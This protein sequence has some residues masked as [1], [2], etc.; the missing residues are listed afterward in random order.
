MGDVAFEHEAF[1]HQIRDRGVDLLLVGLARG[2][3]LLEPGSG[4]ELPG[5][6]LCQQ[7]MARVYGLEGADQ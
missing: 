1:A 3:H 7:L 2:M 6:E 5:S 4:I